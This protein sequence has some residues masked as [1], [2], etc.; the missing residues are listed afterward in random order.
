[1]TRK[2]LLFTLLLVSIITS[3]LTGVNPTPVHSQDGGGVEL[4]PQVIDVWPLPGVEMAANNPLTITFDQP[5]D[6]ASVVSALTFDPAIEGSLTWTDARTVAF[7]PTATWPTGMEYAVT[8]GTGA[9]TIIGV[10]FAEPYAF[11]V[12]TV[13]PL[14]VSTVIPEDGSTGIAADST[15]IVTFNR[16]VVPLVTSSEMGDLPVPL[17]FSPAIEGKGEWLNTAIYQFTPSVPLQ[18]GTT[19]TLTVAS[20]LTSVDGA[21]LADDFSWSFSTLPPQILSLS[22]SVNQDTVPLES[23]IT[24]TFSQPMDKAS[25]EAAFSVIQAFTSNPPIAGAITWSDDATI[26]TF[27]PAEMLNINSAYQVIIKPTA[28]SA[29]GEAMLDLSTAFGNDEGYI[30]YTVP[31][32]GIDSTYPENNATDVNPGYGAKIYFVSPM[33]TETLEGKIQINPEPEV[34]TPQVNGNQALMINFAAKPLTQYTITLLAGAEDVYG[35]PIANDYT[36]TYSTVDIPVWATPITNYSDVIVTGAYRENTT[37]AVSVSGK[38]TVAFNLYRLDIALLE[39]AVNYYSDSR[40]AWET[41]DNLLRSWTQ[42]FD[43][44]G[45]EGIAREVYLASEQG[46]QLAPGLYWL[47]ITDESNLNYQSYDQVLSVV[48][49]GITF[50]RT[51]DEGFIWVTDMQTGVPVADTTVTVYYQGEPI[52]RGQTDANGI[53]RSP[54]DSSLSNSFISVVADGAGVYGAWYGW[55]GGTPPDQTTYVYTDRPIYR[56]GETIYFRGVIRDKNDMTYTVP[57]AQTIW[58]QAEIG[59]D[60]VYIYDAPLELS[61]YGTFSG[62]IQIPEDAQLGDGYINV[63]LDSEALS[64]YS[65]GVY[66]TVAEFRVPEYEVSVTAQQDEIFQGDTLSAIAKSSYYFGGAVSNAQVSWY[67]TANL[68]YFN[69]TGPGSYSFYNDEWEYYYYQYIG[70]G[71]GTTDSNGQFVIQTDSTK[72]DANAPLN[73][74]VEATITDESNQAITSRTTVLAHPADIYVGTASNQYFGY[75]KDPITVDLIA[76]TADSQPI[77]G[78]HLDVEVIEQ[79]WVQVPDS[80]QFGVYY[81]QQDS[82]PVETGTVTTAADG[83]ASYTFTPPNGGIFRIKVTG[84]DDRERANSSTRQFYVV[85]SGPIYWGQPSQYINLMADK[86][87][88]KPGDTAQIL[89]PHSLSGESTVL[90]TV[91]REGILSYDVV[92]SEGATLVYELPIT[93]DFVSAV[94]VSATIVKGID[95]NN[96]NPTIR[97]GSVYFSV[98][99][100][101]Q[102]LNVT[103]TPS[104]EITQPGDTVTFDVSTTDAAGNPVSAE[105]GIGLTDKAILS[106]LPPNS[107][108]MEDTFYGYQ[109]NYV[110]SYYSL[111]SLL[112]ELTDKNIERARDA[113]ES[114]AL[115]PAAADGMGGGGGGGGGGGLTSVNVR[116]NFE[117]TPLWAPHVVTDANG[118]ASV[119]I[120]LPDNLTTWKLDARAVTLDT[121]VGQT[122]TEIVTTLPL[123]IRPVAPRFFVV[124]DRVQ[125]AAVV[126]NNTPE[127]QTV[128]VILESNGVTL[129]S[130]AT[131]TVTIEPAARARIEWNVVAEDVPFIDLTFGVI[132]TDYSDAVKPT[133][134]TG[135]DGTIPVYRYTAPDTVGTAGML[136][137][138]GS[139]TEGIS[140]PTRLDTSRGELT[141][142]LDPSLAAT[143]TDS[144]DY[145][146][147]YPH[148]CIEQTVSRF[149]PNIVTYS[150]L[151]DLGIQ[152]PALEANLFVALEEGL[153]KLSTQQNPDGGWGWFGGM[154][155]NPY[156]TAYA[157]LALI[158][159]RNAGLDVDATMLDRALNFVRGDVKA[160]TINSDDWQLNRQAFYAYVFAQDGQ[161]DPNQLASLYDQRLRLSYAARAYLLMVYQ[162]LNPDAPEVADL[163]SDLTNAA[164]LSATGAHWEEANDDWW[165]WGSNTRTTAIVLAALVQARP[166]NELLPNV[167]RW[168]MVARKGDHWESTQETV[169]A[170]IGLTKWMVHT[171]EL[172]GS[173]EYTADLNAGNIADT[174]VTPD[175]VRDGQVLRIAVSDLLKDELNRLVIGRGEGDGVLYYTAHLNVRL[176]VDAVEP[177]SKGITVTRQYFLQGD[178]ETPVTSAKVGDIIT[179]RLTITLSQ[180]IYYFVLEDPIPAG[181]EG[182][183]TSLLTTSQRPEGPDLQLVSEEYDPFWYWGWW[184]FDRTELRDEQTNLY[185]DY[186]PDGTYTYTYQIRASVP[187]EF[188][189]IPAHAYAFYFPEVFGTTNGTLFTVEASEAE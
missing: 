95:A 130:D 105:V 37:I 48:N 42:T 128:Q 60:G 108:L 65:G 96:P 154:E 111:T 13:G 26:L 162:Q 166:D 131:Q 172:Q 176:P 140:L 29:S 117:Q 161:A 46:G 25:T 5:M 119:S 103:V 145:L 98:E 132:G 129:E 181:T 88:Y 139:R 157:A 180:D 11:K 109:G 64:Q 69:Y 24:V 170:I 30:F 150:A 164:F 14:Q 87:T 21:V 146:K 2:A 35:N 6:Q 32:P 148:Q 158:E 51:P 106:L 165:N 4:P 118:K 120:E 171:G 100:V 53:F 68:A 178:P 94:S 70:E 79:R 110:Y 71:T 43:S 173:Y 127:A 58:V 138:A 15:L 63:S 10:P 45:F 74:T 122:T 38:P 67:A 182:V 133:L 19:Y 20:G 135:P 156:V 187:G 78:K 123:L 141:I 80:T 89:I 47:V 113:E 33:N 75:E 31:Y 41:S 16:P 168:L 174:T 147:N 137:D 102:R 49:A 52:G 189:T 90:I 36:F 66:F 104:A 73:I 55:N 185:A 126:N 136:M 186:L 17:T 116:E 56:P 23:P 85:G 159:A 125:L 115:A 7:V 84:L 107:G 153:D 28:M 77:A 179:V 61:E 91:E 72:S 27:T 34:W 169:W 1:M 59:Y 54:I 44:N 184:W 9:T 151:K 143:L 149:L 92:K 101:Q 50:K 3:A 93:E 83:T 18:G 155:S 12:K 163:V 160:V 99:P 142:H 22:P 40:P 183:D 97:T 134:A 112:D 177:V 144:F 86:D 39:S 82:I 124:G 121:A 167:V 175:T 8:I 152:D 57:N 188:Q 76:V 114:G 81:W 62:E